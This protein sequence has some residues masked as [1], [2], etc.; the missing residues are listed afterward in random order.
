MRVPRIFV[1]TPLPANTTL[2]LEGDRAHYLLKVLRVEAGRSLILFNGDGF[3]Y[4]ATITAT[5]KKTLQV[6]VLTCIPI[7]NESPI[8]LHLAQVISKGDRMEY[9]LQKAVEL[10]ISQ[11]TPLTSARCDVRLKQDR[12]EKKMDYWQNIIISA[13]EQSGRARLPS[14]QPIQAFE[15]FIKQAHSETHRWILSPELD[16]DNLSRLETPKAAMLMIGPEGGFTTEEIEAA[17]QQGYRGLTLGP[18]VLRTET[19]GVVALSILQH[20]FGDL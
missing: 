2:T 13:C 10:G 20:H 19:A 3:D 14:L 9:T 5:Q 6:E 16:S 11:V 4:Q 17:Q 15:T 12:A 1:D 7:H 18:R 8:K